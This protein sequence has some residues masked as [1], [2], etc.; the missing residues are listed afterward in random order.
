MYYISLANYKPNTHIIMFKSF[1]KKIFSALGAKAQKTAKIIT[2][3][4][5]YETWIG[6]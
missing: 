1:F 6:I 2:K 5:E 3:D 4:E